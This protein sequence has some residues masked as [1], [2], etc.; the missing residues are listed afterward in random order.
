MALD[1]IEILENGNKGMRGF[2]KE[3]VHEKNGEIKEESDKLE[4][5]YDERGLRSL[6]DIKEEQK[7]VVGRG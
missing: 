2:I 6:D 1:K 5:Q 4:R 7:S 3:M